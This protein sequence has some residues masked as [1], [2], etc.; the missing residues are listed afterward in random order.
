MDRA[1]GNFE[2]PANGDV[3]KDYGVKTADR[4]RA[5]RRQYNPED[6]FYKG[7]PKNPKP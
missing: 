3:V 5:V 2:D 1:Y 7:Y 6:I 4:L